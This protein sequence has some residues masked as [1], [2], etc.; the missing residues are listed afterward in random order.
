MLH[1]CI[2]KFEAVDSAK[3]TRPYRETSGV[4]IL[5]V[6]LPQIK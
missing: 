5:F 3:V 2:S 6:R 1:A 4:S